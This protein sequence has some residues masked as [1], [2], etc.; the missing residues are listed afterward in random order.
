MQR[1]RP[2][3]L[4]VRVADPLHP[5]ELN[6]TGSNL[7]MAGARFHVFPPWVER[8]DRRDAPERHVGCRPNSI[9]VASLTPIDA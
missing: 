3:V 5:Q 1:V 4:E 2:H 6:H 9:R 7:P 8:V